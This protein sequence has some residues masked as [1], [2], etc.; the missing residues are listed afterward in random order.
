MDET[1]DEEPPVT[2]NTVINEMSYFN[3]FK[4]G[5]NFLNKID[6]TREQACMETSKDKYYKEMC[7]TLTD[8]ND[9]NNTPLSS[10]K[11]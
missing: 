5:K 7:N 6:A 11:I 3:L 8:Y 4:C 10:A 9:L 1:E 2:D